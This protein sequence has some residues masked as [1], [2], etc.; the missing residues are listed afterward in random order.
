MKYVMVCAFWYHFYN[1]KNVK[2]IHGGV[3][4]LV[5]LQALVFAGFILKKGK[6]RLDECGKEK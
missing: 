1:S 2:N 4:F 3:L 5:K 6:N